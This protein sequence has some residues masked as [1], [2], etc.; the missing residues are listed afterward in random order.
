[1]LVEDVECMP[2]TGAAGHALALFLCLFAVSV[3]ALAYRYQRQQGTEIRP[4]RVYLYDM[5][6]IVLSQLA[7]WLV[8]MS[9]TAL[10]FEE[11]QS[12]SSSASLTL[13]AVQ[14]TPTVHGKAP[15]SHPPRPP[16]MTGVGWYASVFTLDFVV[17]VPVGL[18]LGAL[19]SRLAAKYWMSYVRPYA[20]KHI[21]GIVME[22]EPGDIDVE[23]LPPEAEMPCLVRLAEQNAVLGKYGRR[24]VGNGNEDATEEDE[25]GP[26]L[27]GSWWATQ[28]LAWCL[29]VAASRAVSGGLLLLSL[30]YVPLE[31]NVLLWL[32]KWIS[33]WPFSCG[34]KQWIVAGVMRTT[35]DIAQYLIVDVVN[36]L[37]PDPA[38]A[39]I[40]V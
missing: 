6:K 38:D 4:L 28:C 8:N 21:V 25:W 37:H 22:L 33:S 30:Q 20:Q 32:A 36:K 27:E 16:Y 34:A 11:Y 24:H 14:P 18:A 13:T 15:P 31:W 17:G 12:E 10:A 19:L 7:A 29:C 9:M 1:M 39:Y 35:T 40:E 5:S 26:Q 3:C 23:D 2:F